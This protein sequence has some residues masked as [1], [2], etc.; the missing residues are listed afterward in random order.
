MGWLLSLQF[1]TLFIYYFFFTSFLIELKAHESLFR[2]LFRNVLN[3]FLLLRFYTIH[4]GNFPGGSD[5]KESVWNA[6]DLGLI[7][8]W[9]RSPGEGNGYPLQYSCLE[10]PR[11]R[12]AWGATVAVTESD[13]TEPEQLTLSLSYFSSRS[14]PTLDELS[15]LIFAKL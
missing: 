9:G 2:W 7:P 14:S 15:S 10:N 13:S 12:G 1:S 8:G 4:L 5:G 11:D 6:S 3:Y